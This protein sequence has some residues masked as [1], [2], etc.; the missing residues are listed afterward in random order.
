MVTLTGNNTGIGRQKSKEE[1][2]NVLD[3]V[4]GRGVLTMLKGI[5]GFLWE[6]GTQ[7]PTQPSRRLQ[8]VSLVAGYHICGG[9]VLLVTK[10]FSEEIEFCQSTDWGFSVA[11]FTRSARRQHFFNQPDSRNCLRYQKEN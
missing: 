1:Q 9:W 10:L 7:P 3:L 4:G 2:H 5:S 8:L 6:S 11:Q